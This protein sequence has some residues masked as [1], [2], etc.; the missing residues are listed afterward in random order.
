HHLELNRL[1][2]SLG[3]RDSLLNQALA[4]YQ[5]LCFQLFDD[6]GACLWRLKPGEFSAEL[7]EAA[8]LREDETLLELVLA[9]FANVFGV[10][11]GAHHHKSGSKLGIDFLRLE[12]RHRLP[13][14][15]CA[16]FGS[17]ESSI[18][19]VLGMEEQSHAGGN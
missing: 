10:A 2:G 8:V 17:S 18:A 7:I 6:C 9:P 12:D 3:D 19:L 4:F 14:D 11:E 13:E 15:R 1:A 5:P 16:R